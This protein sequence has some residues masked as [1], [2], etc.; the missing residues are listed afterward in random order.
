[1]RFV[2]KQLSCSDTFII[3]EKKAGFRSISIIACFVMF[4]F[5]FPIDIYAADTKSSNTILITGW[6]YDQL[7]DKVPPLL[8]GSNPIIG[9]LACPPLVRFNAQNDS[10]EPLIFKSVTTSSHNN[11]DTWHFKLRTG[12]YWWNDQEVNTNDI[13]LF[14]KK[15]LE[16][17]LMKKT[18]ISFKENPFTITTTTS[19]ISIKWS[20]EIKY[21]PY[22]ISEVPLWRQISLKT[23]NLLQYECAGIYKIKKTPSQLLLLPSKKYKATKATLAIETKVHTKEKNTA[24]MVME[25]ETASNLSSK[26]PNRSPDIKNKCENTIFLPAMT[27]ISWNPKS[28]I[29]ANQKLKDAIYS[30]FPKD[31]LLRSG[32]GYYGRVVSSPIVLDGSISKKNTVFEDEEHLKLYN[33]MLDQSGF[34]KKNKKGIRINNKG[35]SLVINIGRLGPQL[36]LLEKIIGDIFY[37]LGIELNFVTIKNNIFTQVDGII[38]I[39]MIPWPE[40][41]FM[42]NF[43]SKSQLNF[44]YQFTTGK[45]DHLL[46]DYAIK[47]SNGKKDT[48]LLKKIKT[49]IEDSKLITALLHHSACLNINPNKKL[50]VNWE[51]P[52]WFRNFITTNF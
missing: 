13:A 18:G 25:F 30:M 32:A 23:K 26:L 5:I 40:L 35:V 33:Q 9:R 6:P 31:T 1:M 52:D 20:K 50:S 22:I 27:L 21:G 17:I 14:F 19:E 29:I 28:H 39:A 49:H 34:T 51:N 38:Y 12:I 42:S 37:S 36:F 15:N 44:P 43:H 41:N 7:P 16:D 47:L 2:K 4:N 11:T 48:A 3:N 46:E 45:L 24:E 10:F 8:L